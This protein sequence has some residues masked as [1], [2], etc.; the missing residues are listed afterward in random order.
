M[1][2]L[3]GIICEGITDRIV[4]K[5][6]LHTWTQS[7][8]LNIRELQPIGQQAGGW[9]KVF[10]YCESEELKQA[11][12]FLDFIVIHVDTDFMYHQKAGVGIPK[13][14]Q[15]DMQIGEK[16]VIIEKF[17]DKLINLIGHEFYALYQNRIIFAIAVHEIECWFLPIYFEN[18]DN[19]SF[20][21]NCIQTLNMVLPQKENGL[22][23]GEKKPKYYEIVAKNFK[24]KTF[25]EKFAQKQDSLQAFLSDLEEKINAN[26]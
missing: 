17:K 19:I 25:L 8:G 26:L 16:E 15:I 3:F 24:I 20:T 22:F 10:Q 23:L 9:F 13:R 11:M 1:N 21:D 12:A 6:I 2:Q 14:Y 5:T 18:L 7:T 4:L